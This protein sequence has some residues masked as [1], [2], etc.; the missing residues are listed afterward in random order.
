MS[1]E[2]EKTR[3]KYIDSLYSKKEQKEIKESIERKRMQIETS[4]QDFLLLD[5]EIR[6]IKKHFNLT[7]QEYNEIIQKH[8]LPSKE[9]LIL[10]DILNP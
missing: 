10:L 5:E 3:I 1:T 6:I 8:R 2:A 7:T 9:E 4:I